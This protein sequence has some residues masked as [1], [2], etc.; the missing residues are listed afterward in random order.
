V[1][2]LHAL[3]GVVITF[4]TVLAKINTTASDGQAI[5]VETLWTNGAVG[6]RA[7]VAS[8][9]SIGALVIMKGITTGV[10]FR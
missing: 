9:A 4:Y 10:G 5:K 7:T 8:R 6:S 3:E 2:F 1:L